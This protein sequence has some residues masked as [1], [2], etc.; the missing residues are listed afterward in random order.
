MNADPENYDALIKLMAVKRHEVPPP[1]YFDLLPNRIVSRVRAGEAKPSFWDRLAPLF[2]IRP[3]FAYAFAT[4]ACA[5]LVSAVAFPFQYQPMQT[6]RQSLSYDNLAKQNTSGNQTS[7]QVAMMNST[8]PMS[9]GPSLFDGPS[10]AAT[11]AAVHFQ[12]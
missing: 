6:G 9:S 11:P 12:Y 5:G 10:V 7:G 8:N 1:G 2:V 4:V 3:A